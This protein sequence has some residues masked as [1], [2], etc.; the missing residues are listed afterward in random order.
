[1]PPAPLP[2]DCWITDD[3][4]NANNAS[5]E[6]L[7]ELKCE[8]P[9]PPLFKPDIP[10]DR[11]PII[12]PPGAYE[13]GCAICEGCGESILFRDDDGA[14][15]TLKHWEA[16]GLTCDQL[17]VDQHR[18]QH[19]SPAIDNHNLPHLCNLHAQ[20]HLSRKRRRTPRSE[21]ERREYLRVDP[22]VAQFEPHRVLCGNCDKWLRLSPS[23]TTYSSTRWDEHKKT[24]LAKKSITKHVEA[25]EV[26]KFEEGP[27]LTEM[28]DMW[29][30]ENQDVGKTSPPHHATSPMAVS[31]LNN[32]ITND[33]K[34]FMAN[35]KDPAISQAP[36]ARIAPS[37][38]HG[39]A[40]PG[41]MPPPLQPQSHLE[42]LPGSLS[43]RD[44]LILQPQQTHPLAHHPLSSTSRR[45]SAEQ[46]A[47]AL[48]AD[49][50]IREVEPYRVFCG[51]CTKWVKLKADSSYCAYPWL[52]HRNR[53]VVRY[54][55]RAQ[56]IN[57]IA[58]L[59]AAKCP[60]SSVTVS[61]SYGQD[62]TSANPS[63]DYYGS[64][65]TEDVVSES[66][67]HSVDADGGSHMDVEED[68]V[69][70]SAYDANGACGETARAILRR[71]VPASLADLDS[72]GG[73]QAFIFASVEYLFRTTYEGSDDMSIPALLTYLNAAIPADK[74][75]DFDTNEVL[76][77][78]SA[79]AIHEGDRYV[80][81]G[82]VLRLL[83]LQSD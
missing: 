4:D 75:E 67:G 45:H 61:A 16:H 13:K 72:P 19:P 58:S 46:R 65:S 76:R 31:P 78:A 12:L 9:L 60:I 14:A 81:D 77:A 82:D 73:R 79:I 38:S 29:L 57:V 25:L 43:Q 64:E 1:M 49:V 36:D 54:R 51:L 33:R 40:L 3:C 56:K 2:S 20:G 70:I 42:G 6:P 80:L 66:P 28:G 59:K 83:V 27:I 32:V 68:A 41:H 52:K 30:V 17:H 15:F 35:A 62:N 7:N 55:L 34:A 11:E 8:T 5:H 74:H 53:C 37:S 23:S 48:R 50:L 22:Y 44:P 18:R 47:A 69:M 63:E 10:V 24:C 71:A 39:P 26:R 21:E